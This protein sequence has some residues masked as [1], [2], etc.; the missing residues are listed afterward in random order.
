MPH[1]EKSGNKSDKAK[2][3]AGNNQWANTAGNKP[4]SPERRDDPTVKTQNSPFSKIKLVQ[5]FMPV[6]KH[7]ALIF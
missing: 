5:R 7:I 2:K 1:K 4:F 6:K 3:S